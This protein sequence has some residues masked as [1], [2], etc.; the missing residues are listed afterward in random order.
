MPL[1][2]YIT[3][4]KLIA[5]DSLCKTLLFKMCGVSVQNETK[6]TDTIV[7]NGNSSHDNEND[8]LYEDSQKKK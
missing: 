8:I 2:C 1:K 3:G 5:G 4:H 7:E 6:D